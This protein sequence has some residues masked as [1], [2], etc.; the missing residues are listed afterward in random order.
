M[1]A[2]GFTVSAP[3]ATTVPTPNTAEEGFTNSDTS[4][5]YSSSNNGYTAYPQ[6]IQ[7]A[8]VQEWNL[9][10]EYAL[11][12]TASLQVGYV[13]EKGDHVEDYGNVN[14]YKINGDATSAPFYN[15]KYIGVNGT[16]PELGVGGSGSLLITESR[17][18]MKYNALQAILRQ[19]L[20]HGLEFTVNYTY[21]KSMTNAV[22]NYG[23]NTA[24]YGGW[25]GGFQ[26][27][28]DSHAD[29]GPSGYDIRHNISATGVYALPV[30]HGQEYLSSASRL[31]DEIAG[32]W[33]VSTGVVLYS[34]FPATP[35]GPGNN[36]NSY[37]NSRPNQYRKM[38]IVNRSVDH[39]FGTDPSVTPCLTPGDNGIC[40]F[41]VPSPNTTG[42]TLFGTARPGALRGPGFYNADLSAFKDFRVIGGHKVGF[43]FDAFNAFNIASY[44]NPDNNISDVDPHGNTLFG[45]VSNN[46][47]R[48]NSR[49]LQ[50][51]ANYSF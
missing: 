33:K 29:V 15:S 6:N 3:T 44:N 14:Q 27:Y 34:G 30:G 23:V 8:Y 21:G 43:R 40:A 25:P 10:A 12:R 36:S 32:G 16:E 50:F 38:K 9:T 46:G 24:G 17:A 41:G 4:V 42:G 22:G 1:Q 2:A 18:M 28:Y 5:Q 39:W 26:N 45:N 49:T 47:V 11:T 31:L 48:S 7:P 13:G 51:S 20:N 37:G 35:V 19:R